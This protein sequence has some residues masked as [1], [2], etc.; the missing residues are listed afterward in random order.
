ML[1][2]DHSRAKGSRRL[3]VVREGRLNRGPFDA[4]AVYSGGDEPVKTAHIGTTGTH[5]AKRDSLGH[6]GTA[7]WKGK[8]DGGR[9]LQQP[10]PAA[11]GSR[12]GAG[13]AG[14]GLSG[15]RRRRLRHSRAP[16]RT[17]E[18]RSPQP[19][20]TTIS[21]VTTTPSW[22]AP[23]RSPE[24]SVTSPPFSYP[25]PAGAGSQI[26]RRDAQPD[27][28]ELRGTSLSQS[29]PGYPRVTAVV[30]RSATEVVDLLQS[31][32]DAFSTGA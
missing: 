2:G 18:S 8:P 21:R 15:R 31:Q 32:S 29:L 17:E 1:R 30:R 6:D 28:Y 22:I 14:G 7:T 26:L 16:R 19:V 24:N 5:E 13:I 20:P 4:F 27:G 12:G 9:D 11:A 3:M 10:E 25:G 23:A